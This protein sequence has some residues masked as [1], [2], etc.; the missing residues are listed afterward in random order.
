MRHLFRLIIFLSILVGQKSIQS[1]PIS[2][3]QI[4]M[5]SGIFANY[6]TAGMEVDGY[7]E[8]QGRRGLF[9]ESSGIA[10]LGEQMT[11][12]T[13]LG[14]MNE[15]APDILMG[16]GYSNYLE[17]DND[18]LHEVFFGA[19]SSSITGVAFI[20]LGSELSPN[21]L[22]T[23]NLN[24]FFPFLSIDSSIMCILSKEMDEFGYD[25]FFNMSKTIGSGLSYGYSLSSERYEDEERR[26]FKK[27]GHS[28]TFTV[29]AQGLFISF[30]IGWTF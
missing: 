24:S 29:T 6:G 3:N 19:S 23:L 7:F 11:L 22:G 20:G 25:I 14:I 2:E 13:S 4:G 27:Q 21:Y 17:I 15:V 9:L 10:Q 1:N 8:V 28:K 12:N 30:F 18:V 5:A 26:T 16:G